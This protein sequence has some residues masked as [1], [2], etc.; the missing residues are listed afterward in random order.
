MALKNICTLLNTK[1]FEG[2]I[3]YS[4][5]IGAGKNVLCYFNLQSSKCIC[6]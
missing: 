2:M 4:D 3:N 6:N 1:G 5:E